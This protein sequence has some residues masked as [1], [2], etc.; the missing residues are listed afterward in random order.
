MKN[1]IKIITYNILADY[2]NSEKFILVKKKHLDNNFRKKLLIKKLKNILNKFPKISIFCFQEVGPTQIIFLSQLFLKFNYLYINY[3]DLAIFYPNVFSVKFAEINYIRE[4][5]KKYLKT[6]QRL[7]DKLENFNNIY[8]ILELES[9]T[10]NTFTLCTT[11]L[12]S[13]PKYNKTIKVLQSYLISK[14]LEKY[15]KVIFCGDFNSTPDSNVYKLLSTGIVKYPYY[16]NFKIKNKFTSSYFKFYNKE[17]NIT[18]HTK[19]KITP[20]FTETIDYIWITPDITPIRINKPI[21][22]NEII[23]KYKPMPNKLE[24]SDHFYLIHDLKIN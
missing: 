17:D 6:K 21:L 2:L 20:F 19:N 18:T 15:N 22:K 24:P 3:K 8:I 7:I 16:G 5:G 23:K 11:H 13:N 4:L 10:C 12:T 9:K 1:Q 14:R